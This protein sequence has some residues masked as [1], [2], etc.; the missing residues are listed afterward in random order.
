MPRLRTE[1]PTTGDL[2]LTKPKREPTTAEKVAHQ[3]AA[4]KQFRKD[5]QVELPVSLME[6]FLD[7]YRLIYDGLRGRGTR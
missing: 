7:D 5:G 4:A 1:T 6:K 2:L 3:V